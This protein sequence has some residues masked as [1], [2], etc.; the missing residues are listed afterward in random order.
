[1]ALW[2]GLGN[3]SADAICISGGSAFP[4]SGMTIMYA[5]K[6]AFHVPPWLGLFSLMRQHT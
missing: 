5:L 2:S 3:A 4:L 1:M 6:S